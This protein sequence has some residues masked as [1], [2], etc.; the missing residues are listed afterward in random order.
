[1]GA[2]RPP[3]RARSVRRVP[4]PG[5]RRPDA[6]G[7]GGVLRRDRGPGGAAAHL[8]LPAAKV[9]AVPLH[10]RRRPGSRRAGAAGA[11]GAGRP[12]PGPDGDDQREATCHARGTLAPNTEAEAETEPVAVP[13]PAVWPPEGAD[14]VA[15]DGLYARLAEAGYEYGPVF[16][17]L[18]AAWRDGEH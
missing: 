9:L 11:P 13:F 15:V 6:G 1:T 3:A 5:P 14:P 8:R 12:R 2:A 18:R 10:R 17:G 16:Q 4:G 7:L